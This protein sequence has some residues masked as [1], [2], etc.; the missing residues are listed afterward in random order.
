MTN[1]LLSTYTFDDAWC[2]DTL[3]NY[4][5]SDVKVLILT[6]SLT[7]SIETV[8]RPFLSYGVVE[9]NITVMDL[10]H[11][12][13]EEIVE[14]IKKADI[15]YLAGSKPEKMAERMNDLSIKEE[16]LSSKKIIMG[17]GAGAQIQLDSYH[18]TPKEEQNE[19]G[20]GK[21]LGLVKGLDLELDY[22]CSYGTKMAIRRANKELK[23]QVYAITSDGGLIV[24]KGQVQ[25]IGKVT[26]FE[27]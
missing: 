12:W 5:K 13:S 21:G 18:I 20:Y 9:E 15:I 8:K 27:G 24:M 14:S 22:D 19:F 1:I 4:V 16:L 3:K 11:E 2:Y 6:F 17:C 26:V 7:N 10:E 25:P 23:K